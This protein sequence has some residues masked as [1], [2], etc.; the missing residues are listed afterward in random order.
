MR[1]RYTSLHQ[2]APNEALRSAV[3]FTQGRS[4]N[5]AIANRA[6]ISAFRK[7]N[8]DG[9]PV[10]RGT[11]TLQPGYTNL[12]VLI[13]SD[14]E[15]GSPAFFTNMRADEIALWD[16]ALSETELVATFRAG[17]AGRC[18]I[19]PPPGESALGTAGSPALKLTKGSGTSVNATFGASACATGHSA[20]WGSTNGAIGT[21]TW[22]GGDCTLG[23]GGTATFDPGAPGGSLQYYVIVP[24]DATREGSYGRNSGNTERPAATGLPGCSFTQALGGSCS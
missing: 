7:V 2:N 5:S 20:Y 9:L 15:N 17:S 18:L 10:A 16:R 3:G 12:P 11:T 23:A 8:V 1:S 13:G 6:P 19:L 14:I 24:H 4:Y 22:N 21:L